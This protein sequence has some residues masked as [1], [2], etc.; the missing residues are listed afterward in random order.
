MS[1]VT[2]IPH[3]PFQ[4]YQFFSRKR[5]PAANNVKLPAIIDFGTLGIARSKTKILPLTCNIPVEFEY[6]ISILE[7]DDAF[8]VTPL[9]GIIPGDSLTNVAITYMPTGCRTST[10]KIAVDISQFDARPQVITIMGNCVP[11]LSKEETVVVGQR[12]V[13]I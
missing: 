4:H 2:R 1:C 9:R 6:E 13:G 10:M 12:E 3:L 8:E 11:G 5:Y 7:N